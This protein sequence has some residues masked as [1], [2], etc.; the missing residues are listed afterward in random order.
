ML[1]RPVFQSA[2]LLSQQPADATQLNN[3][4]IDSFAFGRQQPCAAQAIHALGPQPLQHGA[5]LFE[6]KAERLH[7]AKQSELLDQGLRVVVV[8]VGPPGHG[9]PSERATRSTYDR[10]ALNLA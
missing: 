9:P 3:L 10:S 4:G 7:G 1:A 8:V 2:L 6:G 5:D